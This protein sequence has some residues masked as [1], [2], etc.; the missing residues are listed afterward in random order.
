MK[1]SELINDIDFELSNLKRIEQES[2]KLI[3]IVKDN[4][5][6]I[7]Q[8]SAAALML[9]Q[10]YNGIENTLKRICKFK[11]ITLPSGEQSHIELFQW[12]SDIGKEGLPVFF[13]AKNKEGFSILR[14]FRHYV[15]HGY[16]FYLEWDKLKV[17]ILSLEHLLQHFQIKIDL[18][19]KR[20]SGGK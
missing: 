14:R 20:Q 10:F 19:I 8:V 17:G 18:F 16:A 7:Y 4:K 12:F 2:S 13:D 1:L 3:F 5:A 9:A 11:K 6:D 15:F